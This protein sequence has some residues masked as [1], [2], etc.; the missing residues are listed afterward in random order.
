MAGAGAFRETSFMRSATSGAVAAS[1]AS[2]VFHPVDTFKTV[3]QRGV[4]VPASVSGS[5]AGATAAA[6]S[7]VAAFRCVGASREVLM[8][9]VLMRVLLALVLALAL[10]LM[11]WCG[12]CW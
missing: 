6:S 5:P 4:P 1:F 3:L 12:S 9:R 11:C 10:V 8:P 7:L 2:V